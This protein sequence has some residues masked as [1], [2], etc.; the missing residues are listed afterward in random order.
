MNL[1][2]EQK[3]YIVGPKDFGNVKL[4]SY[5]NKTD[6]EKINLKYFPD[7]KIL[8]LN[9]K[10]SSIKKDIIYI[11]FFKSICPQNYCPKFDNKANLISYDGGHLTPSGSEYIY[12]KLKQ[13]LKLKSD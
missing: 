4:I 8:N 5:L 10:L 7:S 3:L 6:D 9:N 12:H 2:D 13:Q 11:D 1:S